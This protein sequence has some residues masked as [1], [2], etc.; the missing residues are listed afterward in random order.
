MYRKYRARRYVIVLLEHVPEVITGRRARSTVFSRQ[1]HPSNGTGLTIITA[2][3]LGSDY[4]IFFSLRAL[5]LEAIANTLIL[6]D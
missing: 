1:G 3:R 5:V 6:V 2:L 4:P